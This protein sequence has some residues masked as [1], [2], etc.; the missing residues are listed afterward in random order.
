MSALRPRFTSTPGKTPPHLSTMALH[1][2]GHGHSREITSRYRRQS[3][4]ASRDRLLHKVGR[5]RVICE[6][7]R[8]RGKKLHLEECHMPLRSSKG[9]NHRQWLTIHFIRFPR[10][11]RQ[12]E[13]QIELF[14]PKIPLS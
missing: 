4:H 7:Q 2:V 14:K 6:N 13:H 8:L 12:V 3:L 5:S 9:N 1:E 10:L 11:L